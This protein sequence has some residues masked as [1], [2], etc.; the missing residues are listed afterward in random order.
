MHKN[1]IKLKSVKNLIEITLS[2]LSILQVFAIDYNV[3]Y[4]YYEK[5]RKEKK[6]Y[7]KQNKI[8]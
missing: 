6:E 8:N 3:K 7:E 5:K 4:E 2:I 1:P